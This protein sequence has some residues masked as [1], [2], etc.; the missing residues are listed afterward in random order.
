MQR[1]SKNSSGNSS[2]LYC[3]IFSHFT[4]YKTFLY[5]FFHCDFS[6]SL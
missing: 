3:I 4:T 6:I 5:Y 2:V 1:S